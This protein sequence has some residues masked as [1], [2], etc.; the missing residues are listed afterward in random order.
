MGQAYLYNGG[1]ETLESYGL[2][3]IETPEVICDQMPK[4]HLSFYLN[5][6]SYVLT[7]PW[8]FAHAGLNPLR[9]LEAQLDQDL[10]W[11]R[12]E[13]ISNLHGFDKTIVFGHT[14]HQDI[15]FHWPY[16]MGID[17]G[18]CF[19]N[20]LT[21]VELINREIFQIPANTKKIKVSKFPSVGTGK[22]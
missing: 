10:F 9:A 21:C 12:D 6:E 18:L 11:I 8:V 2:S 20:M 16:K 15:Y 7:G 17:T 5:L 13:F 4:E 14:P 3:I 19:G 1:V 22:K